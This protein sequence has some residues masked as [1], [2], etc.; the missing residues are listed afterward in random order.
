MDLVPLKKNNLGA[1]DSSSSP[2]FGFQ[3]V[4]LDTGLFDQRPLKDRPGIKACLIAPPETPA[5]SIFL[6]WQANQ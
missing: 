1:P 4:F 2:M 3:N 6:N 5:V